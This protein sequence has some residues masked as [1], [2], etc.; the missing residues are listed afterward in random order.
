[1]RESLLWKSGGLAPRLTVATVAIMA[2]EVT[3][4]SRVESGATSNV[5][6]EESVMRI[7]PELKALALGE[8]A[9]IAGMIREA[10]RLERAERIYRN[11]LR[12]NR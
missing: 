4:E 10:E 12:A 11:K 3:S 7:H 9:F 6:T 8:A 5:N 2:P 1:M